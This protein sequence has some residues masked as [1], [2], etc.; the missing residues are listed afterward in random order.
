MI[1]IGNK[2][3]AEH[4]PGILG[5][6][7][8]GGVGGTLGSLVGGKGG[9]VAGALAGAGI[10]GTA[11]GTYLKER[12]QKLVSNLDNKNVRAAA[13]WLDKQQQSRFSEQNQSNIEELEKN[14]TNNLITAG[15]YTGGGTIGVHI[16]NKLGL[17]KVLKILGVSAAPLYAPAA[18]VAGAGTTGLGI[19]T[20]IGMGG[21]PWIPEGIDLPYP[22]KRNLDIPELG[23]HN[24]SI[25]LNKGRSWEGG[26]I[27]GTGIKYDKHGD[28]VSKTYPDELPTDPM[29]G[30]WTY[31]PYEK[32]IHHWA[33]KT[34]P[35]NPDGDHFW[36]RPISGAAH[37]LLDLG[38]WL[39]INW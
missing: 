9:T 26:N 4:G 20:A 16:L 13:E 7:L 28:V 33:L 10:G 19:G 27:R 21:H 22:F 15:I 17:F 25:G 38:E 35:K 24:S 14:R 32:S 5:A 2:F 29:N 36:K 6:L 31:R 11:G 1:K 30:P 34:D 3:L 37:G 39:G 18:A 12:L 23:V 8:G